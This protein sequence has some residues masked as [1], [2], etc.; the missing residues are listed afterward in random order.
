MLNDVLP[1]QDLKSQ[2]TVIS[3]TEDKDLAITDQAVKNNW[4]VME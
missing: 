1:T 2:S 4:K 3:V